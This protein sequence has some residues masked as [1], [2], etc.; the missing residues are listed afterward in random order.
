MRDEY[1]KD[2]SG[3]V[4][5]LHKP[6]IVEFLKKDFSVEV[7]LVGGKWVWSQNYRDSYGMSQMNGGQTADGFGID[8]IEISR[9][10]NPQAGRVQVYRLR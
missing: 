2:C 8:D 10:F 9:G 6:G 3:P 5:K 7:V 4:A 1:H